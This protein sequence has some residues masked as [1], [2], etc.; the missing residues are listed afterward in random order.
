MSAA[1]SATVRQRTVAPA[2]VHQMSG[3]DAVTVK[4]GCCVERMHGV[5]SRLEV[6][7]L[8]YSAGN[9]NP[10]AAKASA[11]LTRCTGIS[12]SALITS[13]VEAMRRTR[14]EPTP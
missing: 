3:C 13:G 5:P 9:G 10:A 4:A 1:D 7:L 2:R 11:T 8:M 12:L 6:L 14:L